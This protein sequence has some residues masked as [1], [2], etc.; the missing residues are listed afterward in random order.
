[1]KIETK[2][3]LKL[4]MFDIAFEFLMWVGIICCALWNN[5]IIETAFFYIC[6]ATFRYVFP[7]EYHYRHSKKPLINILCCL[8]WSNVIFWVVIPNMFPITISLFSSVISGCVVNYFLYKIQDYIDLK[9]EKYIN[10][11]NIYK[12]SEEE[13]R[14]HA[15]SLK[16]SEQIVDTL[17]LR[18]IH[19]YKWVEI[20]QERNYT[21]EGIRYHKEKLQKVLNIKL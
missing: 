10:T 2:L 15:H 4:L 8:F 1:M 14:Q 20:M 6:W 18:V 13:L 21:K 5:R 9:E 12:M 17:V 7:K 3:K 16:I 19:N 11:V